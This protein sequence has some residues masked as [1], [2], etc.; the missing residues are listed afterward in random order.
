[1]FK[2]KVPLHELQRKK[3][4][5]GVP[6]YG[7]QCLHAQNMV[8][9]EDGPLS[10]S[11]LV[12]SEYKGRVKSYD[13]KTKT[14]CWNKIT[15]HIVRKNTEGKKWV[16]VIDKERKGKLLCTD[17][18]ECAVVDDI[19][20]PSKVSYQQ[21]KDLAGKYSVRVPEIE[22]EGLYNSDQMSAIIG[23][24]LGD[25]YITRLGA[26]RVTHS[27]KQ[28]PYLIHL[29]QLLGVSSKTIKKSVS[30]YG[31]DVYSFI[32]PVNVQL[33]ELRKNYN[34]K[35]S[36]SG[37]LGYL[38]DRALAYW[39]MDDGYRVI[40][41]RSFRMVSN[42]TSN[43]LWKPFVALSTDGFSESDVDLLVTRLKE[44]G[45]D[46]KKIPFRKYF[47]IKILDHDAFFSAI[48]PHVH[49]TLA[50]KLPEEYRSN[51]GKVYPSKKK[52]D[53]TVTQVTE[54]KEIKGNKKYSKLYD[55]EVEN[56]HNFVANNTLVHNCTGMFAR[57]MTDLVALT[58]KHKIPIQI[59]YLFNESL[60]TRARAYVCDEF[61][62]SDSTHMI[63]IDSD[64]GF[65]A[66]DVI[67]ML[68][69]QT[70]DS[71][72]D[73]LCAP[74]PKKSHHKKNRVLTED[75]WQTIHDLVESKYSK[76][77]LSM[78]PEGKFEWK[79]VIGH[80]RHRHMGMPWVKISTPN[81][82][83]DIVTADHHIAVLENVLDPS[84][85]TWKAAG[86]ILDTDH[87]VRYPRHVEG[88]TN[89]ENV[90]YSKE[91]LSFLIGTLLGDGSIKK[92]GYLVFGHSEDQLS[93]LELKA[94]L[95]GGSLGPK[96]KVGSYK[97]KEY[98]A[99]FLT[100]PRNSQI[101]YLR[102]LMYP[103][104]KKEFGPVKHLIDDKALAMW[105]MDDGT[106]SSN[107]NGWNVIMCTDGFGEENPEI[108]KF[109]LERF[110]IES[111][112]A[113][114]GKRQRIRI[115]QSSIEK[116]FSII[117]K[118]VTTDLLYKIP[119]QY[120]STEKFDWSNVP[121]LEIGAKP[122]KVVLCKT[123]SD[124]YDITVQDNANFVS[125]YYVVS[126]CIAWEKIKTA[127]VKGFADKNP[128]EL[129]RYVG[130]YVFNPKDTGNG[131][132]IMLNQPVEILEGGT[133]FMMIRRNTFLK[134]QER[135]PELWYK[136]D[137]VRTKEFDG[138]RPVMMYF[139]CAIDRGYDFGDA[140]RVMEAVA[141][142]G[143]TPELIEKTKSMLEGEKTASLR[144]LSE[145]YFFSRNVQKANMKIW[146]LPWIK[147]SHTG[148]YVFGGSLGDLA[149]IGASATAD[150]N[151]LKHVREEPVKTPTLGEFMNNNQNKQPK[152]RQPSK[153]VKI[154][155][156]PNKPNILP[157]LPGAEPG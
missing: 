102:G 114:S 1:M 133:G 77:V 120:Q 56:T 121:K 116:F 45:I 8:E 100:S 36:V 47:R 127:V 154:P 62:R 20:F 103:N 141:N 146:L 89:S 132:R 107:G 11:D 46:S 63:F 4:F 32:T 52:L 131:G 55:I 152:N 138:S 38:N 142:D 22:G 99:R 59:Y 67:A 148:T 113:I 126:N 90:L 87:V 5:I 85:I 135:F 144:Y 137:H 61:M 18:H 6:M 24:F 15:R 112:I 79:P 145:D 130:D 60:I 149:H 129:E 23:M 43:K 117:G 39:F 44:M 156:K 40:D 109:L 86:D 136:P 110:G 13:E 150:P 9:T 57:S 115:R 111:T 2:I 35:K 139:D 69:L 98:F 50:Y 19:F 119:E 3:L 73:V 29:T 17:D 27:S 118:Y 49:E 51:V 78:N 123:K 108:Q 104:G 34:P 72:Y 157:G 30:G 75:G 28:L 95:F 140:K 83:H 14:F 71:P 122:V 76:K 91:Q 41:Q 101:S 124:Q 134:Y 88:V 70:D 81:Q 151:Q 64:I 80:S 68:A 82:P 16:R 105:Y 25:G 147:L 42:G 84:N 12:K 31:S 106:L 37:I 33:K 155:K 74:Y 153:P 96:K 66:K 65:D 7:G 92:R 26:L 125:N 97:G 94:Q 48:A 128:N 53:Y 21:A 10:M 54:V 93:Y 58:T 143:V